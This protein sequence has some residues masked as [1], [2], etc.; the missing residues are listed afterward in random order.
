[1]SAATIDV[2]PLSDVQPLQAGHR[3]H[4]IAAAVTSAVVLVLLAVTLVILLTRGGMPGPSKILASN[5]YSNIQVMTPAD[6]SSSGLNQYASSGAIGT[7]GSSFEAVIAIKPADLAEMRIGTALVQSELPAG[8]QAYMS[9]SDLVLSGPD[10][11][12]SQLGTL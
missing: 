3:K 7:N 12:L 5:G 1:M 11:S 9:G 10:S 6:L 2:Q 4:L 8:M